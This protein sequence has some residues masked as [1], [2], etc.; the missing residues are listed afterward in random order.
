MINNQKTSVERMAAASG[1]LLTDRI[2]RLG[3]GFAVGIFVARHYG[4]SDWGALNYVL[5]SAILFGSIASAGSENLILRDLAQ[6][7]SVQEHAD[8][9]KTAITLRLIFGILAYAGLVIL[10]FILQ[11]FGLPLYLAMVYG[12]VFIFQVSEIWEYQLRIEDRLPEVAGMHILT[13]FCF[14]VLKLVSISLAWPLIAIAALMSGEYAANWL[15]LARYRVRNWS[16]LTGKFQSQYARKLLLSSSMVMLS[17]FL[18]ACQSRSEYYL[19]AHYMDLES[20]G[21]YA[22]ALKFM[23]VIDV[24]ILVLTMALV[25]E[26][27]KRDHVELPILAMRTYL[28]GLIFFIGA[29]LLMALIYLLFPLVYGQ[30]YLPA[31]ELIPWLALRP[32]FIALGA[33]RGIFLVMEGR[34]RYAPVC[35][36]VGLLTTIASSSVLIPIWGLKGAA[37]SGLIGLII[38]NFVID[39]FFKPQNIFFIL[40]CYRQLPYVFHRTVEALSLR[41]NHVK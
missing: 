29:L 27:A 12:L 13:G 25:P 30:K 1:W 33:I 20:L 16:G 24:L 34:L 23:E 40:N 38:S 19:I 9:Q 11:G 22:A 3:L 21:L 14:S 37:I 39:I 41:K 6:S 32:L 10:V 15:L 2:L 18:V 5:A 17:G 7:N 8:I 4:P 36:A 31:Q 26:L 28:L 35:A